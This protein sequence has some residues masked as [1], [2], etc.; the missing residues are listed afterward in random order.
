MFSTV[1][2]SFQLF[3]NVF[4]FFKHFPGRSKLFPNLF[5]PFPNV[6]RFFPNVS[7]SFSDTEKFNN[8]WRDPGGRF[9][10]LLTV[11]DIFT[12]EDIRQNLLS[13]ARI[14]LI[15]IFYL[16]YYKNELV[17]IKNKNVDDHYGPVFFH[18]YP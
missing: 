9:L 11:R 5:S 16:F 14:K 13:I 17:Y 10:D 4:E 12:H 15:F 6:F 2:K 3:S 18:K 8:G 1:F 7:R